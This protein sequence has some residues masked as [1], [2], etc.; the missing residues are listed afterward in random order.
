MNKAKIISLIYSLDF[1]ILSLAT[2]VHAQGELP[3]GAC[4]QYVWD[5]PNLVEYLICALPNI[6][7]VAQMI[8][9]AIAVGMT[10]Y[11]IYYTARN[12]DNPK[13]LSELGMKWMWLFLFVLIV[14]SGGGIIF[15]PLTFLGFEGAEYWIGEFN[16]VLQ[17]L[18]GS[19]PTTPAPGGP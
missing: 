8:G 11:L 17:R 15:I 14:A 3:A 18:S 13:A 2:K 19:G 16:S 5:N 10:I 4:S 6:F 12:L 1:L 7:F 9:A